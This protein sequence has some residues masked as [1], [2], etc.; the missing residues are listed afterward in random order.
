MTTETATVIDP[1]V[2][3]LLASINQHGVDY[4]GAFAKTDG[5]SSN[6]FLAYL[7]I[8]SGAEQGYVLPGMSG[9]FTAEWHNACGSPLSDKSMASAKSKTGVWIAAGSKGNT[10]RQTLDTMKALAEAPREDGKR[11]DLRYFEKATTALRRTLKEGRPLD[12]NEIMQILTGVDPDK[13]DDDL[14][15][16]VAALG[17]AAGA[18]KVACEIDPNDKA[19]DAMWHNADMAYTLAKSKMEARDAN[20]KLANVVKAHNPLEA[21]VTT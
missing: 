18:L 19:I 14:S 12:T 5:T 17:R 2:T 10:C 13:V 20:T 3:T 9:V 4:S 11:V 15:R 7:S 1:R 21:F 6:K 16:L 8:M